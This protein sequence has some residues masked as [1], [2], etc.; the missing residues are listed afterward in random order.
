M[1][2][3]I[4]LCAL[5]IM[6]LLH[7][8][9]VLAENGDCSGSAMCS[10][11]N[12]DDFTMKD[13]AATACQHEGDSVRVHDHDCITCNGNNI[14]LFYQGDGDIGMDEACSGASYLADNLGCKRCGSVNAGNGGLLTANYI[15]NCKDL[16]GNKFLF[17]FNN[18]HTVN[19][20]HVKR[21]NWDVAIKLAKFFSGNGNNFA[22]AGAACGSGELV[23]C[24]SGM[25]T[26]VVGAIGDIGQLYKDYV[27]PQNKRSALL[28]G[29]VGESWI[30]GGIEYTHAIAHERHLL[31]G[32]NTSDWHHLVARDIHTNITH[33]IAAR[34]KGKWLNLHTIQNKE[35]DVSGLSFAAFPD[36]A[37]DWKSANQNPKAWG[38]D[39]ANQMHD[40]NAGGACV[41][42]QHGDKVDVY[43]HIQLDNQSDQPTFDARPCEA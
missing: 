40:N 6:L 12:G 25:I 43:S 8:A 18:I 38:D 15:T 22:S 4:Y 35:G 32:M 26:A 42:F 24:V 13:F 7:S 28:D 37:E 33:R 14:C 20:T 34:I 31:L 36:D 41:N 10:R 11:A 30:N 19:V 3:P 1:L 29:R 17:P 21:D 23:S 39:I 16:G 5:S 9:T 27:T 2:Q